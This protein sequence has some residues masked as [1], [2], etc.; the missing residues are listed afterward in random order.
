MS[1]IYSF[2]GS[3]D[4]GN[5]NFIFNTPQNIEAISFLNSLFNDV[6]NISSIDYLYYT[7]EDMYNKFNNM[8]PF[9]Y[10]STEYLDTIKKYDTLTYEKLPGEKYYNIIF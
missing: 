7:N 9:A 1:L 10:V 2:G 8:I 3:I 4:D 6:N 5:G